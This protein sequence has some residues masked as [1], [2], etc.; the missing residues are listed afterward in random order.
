VELGA[1]A[2]LAAFLRAAGS[3]PPGLVAAEASVLHPTGREHHF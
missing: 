2:G 1:L 3:L